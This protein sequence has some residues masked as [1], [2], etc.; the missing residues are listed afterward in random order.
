MKAAAIA[1]CLLF[2]SGL[3]AGCTPFG[4]QTANRGTIRVLALGS[5]TA[6]ADSPGA[7]IRNALTDEAGQLNASGGVLGHKVA[8]VFSDDGGD[9]N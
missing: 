2:L 8:V 6:G 7:Y 1:V 4:G 3:L 5:F 9:P